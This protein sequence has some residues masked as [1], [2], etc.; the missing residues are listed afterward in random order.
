MTRSRSL[1]VFVCGVAV[2][3]LGVTMLLQLFGDHIHAL[4]ARGSQAQVEESLKIGLPIEGLRAK[5]ILDTFDQRRESD[6]AHEATD[7]MAPRGTP[8][9]AVHDGT[10]RKLFTSRPGGLTI[11]QFD[12]SDT[13][14][15]YYAHLDRYEKGLAEGQSVQ[16]GAIIG[17]VGSSGNASPAAP[18][19]HFAI[20]RLDPEKHWWDGTPINPYPLLIHA[21]ESAK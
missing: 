18:H 1:A 15:F 17:Y 3:A 8:V 4:A 5:D 20:V 13:Y 12:S 2:G 11:Y 19:L 16:Q 21:Q 10:I 9:H 7:I 14:C 6:R